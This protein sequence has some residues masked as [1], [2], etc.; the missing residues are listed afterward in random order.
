[1]SMEGSVIRE[2]LIRQEPFG[3]RRNWTLLMLRSVCRFYLVVFSQLS[4]T[5]ECQFGAITAAG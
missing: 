1:M 3:K 2:R 5:P 4:K